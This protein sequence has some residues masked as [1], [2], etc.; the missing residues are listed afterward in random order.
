MKR[1]IAL[2]MVVIIALCLVG[3]KKG[4]TNT[5]SDNPSSTTSES[6]Q[7]FELKPGK[8][9]TEFQ[10]G[11]KKVVVCF[12]DS[13]TWGWNSPGRYVY[14]AQLEANLDGQYKVINAGIAGEK[15]AAIASR[16]N[17][18]DFCLTND[19]V[20]KKGQDSVSLDRELFSTADGEVIQYL[21]FGYELPHDRIII[22]G[23][24]YKIEYQKGEEYQHGIYTIVRENTATALTLKKG[25]PVKYDYSEQFD[26]CYVA[27]FL[28]GANDGDSGSDKL[29]ERYK[30]FAETYERYIIIAPFFYTDNTAKFEAEFGKNVINPRKYAYERHAFEDYNL[31][32]TKLDEWCIK[33]GRMPSTFLLNNNKEEMHLSSWGYKLVADMVY[34]KGVELGYWK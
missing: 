5:P 33:K 7:A 15:T 14:P 17:A 8:E 6:E 18:I 19:V 13:I 21:G 2:I 25:T 23:V 3:C 9:I 32:P 30:K 26:E 29:L 20:F 10:N 11:T 12:G 28:S 16:A 34:K 4:P 22:D 1:I 27:V 31:T 24:K